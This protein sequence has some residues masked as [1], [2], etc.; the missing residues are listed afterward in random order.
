ML[1]EFSFGSFFLG[2]GIIIAG[3]AFMRWHQVIADNLG[4]GV[5]SYDKFKLYALITCCLGFL[6]MLNLHW[7]ILGNILKM[8][9]PSIK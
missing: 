6:V 2:I 9:F 7:F 5:S 8:M 4:G 1:Y 3:V